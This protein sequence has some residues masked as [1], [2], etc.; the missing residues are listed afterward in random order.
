MCSLWVISGHGRAASH[1][2]NNQK[3]FYNILCIL[4]LKYLVFNSLNLI[5]SKIIT[6]LLLSAS[7]VV[8]Y[9]Y[10]GYTHCGLLHKVYSCFLASI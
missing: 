6:L 1:N 7:Q 8:I 4:C 2:F 3:T 10:S 9:S 5:K